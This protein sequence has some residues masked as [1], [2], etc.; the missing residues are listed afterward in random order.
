M[1]PILIAAN[2]KR[3][4]E[5]CRNRMYNR[6][7]SKPKPS[8]NAQLTACQ[9]RPLSRCTRRTR[10]VVPIAHEVAVSS[11]PSL[12]SSI[13]RTIRPASRLG[14]RADPRRRARSARA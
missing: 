11:A 1:L 6:S 14:P 5:R 13:H 8:A 2:S 4:S 12:S 9:V 3:G 10:N 7:P